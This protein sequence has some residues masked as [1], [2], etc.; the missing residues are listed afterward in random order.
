MQTYP[1]P[2]I[3]VVDA[4]LRIGWWV[5]RPGGVRARATQ[6]AALPSIESV[7]RMVTAGGRSEG[8]QKL[9]IMVVHIIAIS[10]RNFKC[11]R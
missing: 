1:S 3:A 2:S 11:P 6:Q 7:R 10:L 9:Q 4:G 8:S 5:L